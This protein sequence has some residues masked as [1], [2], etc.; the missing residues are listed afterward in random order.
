MMRKSNFLSFQLVLFIFEIINNR[1]FPL[2]YDKSVNFFPNV[3]HYLNNT[4]LEYNYTAIIPTIYIGEISTGMMYQNAQGIITFLDQNITQLPDGEYKLGIDGPKEVDY[5]FYGSEIHVEEG[6][7]TILQI[8]PGCGSPDPVISG[9]D[10][11]VIL[12]GLTSC[13]LIIRKKYP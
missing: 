8:R 13:F 1:Q 6:N 5:E 2:K 7:E 4:K 10:G 12:L 9:F 11:I 3:T